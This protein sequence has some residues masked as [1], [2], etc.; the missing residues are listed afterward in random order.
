MGYVAAMLIVAGLIA[1]DHLGVFGRRPATK[2]GLYRPDAETLA[3]NNAADMRTYHN[4]S[5]KVTRVVDGDTLD[6][7]IRDEIQGK[8]FTRIRLWGVDTPE[9]VKPNTPKQHFG[10]EATRFTKDFCLGMAKTV[11][12]EL[13][14]DC[15]KTRGKYGRLL[16]YVSLRSAA[17]E[18]A[19]CLNAELIRRG[20]GYSD[21]RFGHP[22]K[23]EFH[24]LQR[25]A[26]QGGVGLWAD[27]RNDD[28]PD[29]YQNEIKLGQ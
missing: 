13:V 10:P 12:L 19:L 24:E 28:L 17:G 9:T 3:R 20:F 4:K 27:A 18:K 16:A 15:K 23:K 14:K 5:F 11:R 7:D 21:P 1:G 29:Y 2:P 25:L 22:R 8:E 26:R 6:V